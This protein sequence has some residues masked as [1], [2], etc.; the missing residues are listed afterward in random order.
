MSAELA[1]IGGFASFAIIGIWFV[2][3]LSAQKERDRKRLK[4]AED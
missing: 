1:I 4:D 2:H 3:A